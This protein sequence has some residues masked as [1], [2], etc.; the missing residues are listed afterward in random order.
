MEES[1]CSNKEKNPMVVMLVSVEKK[2]KGEIKYFKYNY[3]LFIQE[4]IIF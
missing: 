3:N 4:I 1:C 2:N